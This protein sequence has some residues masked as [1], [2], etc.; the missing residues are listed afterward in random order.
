MAPSC[1]VNPHPTVAASASPATSGAISR[2]L[3]YAEMKPVKAP[4]P[5]WSSAWYPCSP[6]S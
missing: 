6:T 3:K 4:V 2:V 1:A 5:S